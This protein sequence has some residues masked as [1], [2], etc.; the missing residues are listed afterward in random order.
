MKYGNI[1]K[2]IEK[3]NK[4]SFRFFFISGTLFTIALFI[5]YVSIFQRETSKDARII[6]DLVNR[7]M[8]YSSHENFE[9]LML[10]YFLTEVIA[11]IEYPIII[12]D[13]NHIPEFWKNID[14]PEGARWES[15]PEPTKRAMYARLSK[16]RKN[17]N[18][19]IP[20]I[21][22]EDSEQ[23]L[24]YVYYEDSKTI[25]LL[26]FLPYIEVL[27]IL[28]FLSLGTFALTSIHQNEKRMIWV[29]LA[30]ET[31]HQFG[32]PISSLICWLDFLKS[33]VEGLPAEEEYLAIINEMSTDISLLQ[34][35]TTRFGKFGTDIT[36]KTV[37][38]DIL[39]DKMLMYYKKRLPV[40]EQEI[41]ISYNPL[42]PH[43]VLN[44]DEDLMV[45]AF[46]NIINN[47][48]DAM[49]LKAG[50]I[51]IDSYLDNKKYVILFTDQGIG[52]QRSM[53]EPIFLPGVTTKKRGWGLGLSMSKR[54]ICEYHQGKI[55]VAQSEI[56]NGTTIEVVL[57]L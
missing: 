4:R 39:I 43:T 42:N 47:S 15:L 3:L 8:A 44:I 31:A 57:P 23:V 32:T 28:L 55:R 48:I 10:Q 45:W 37:D 14:A 9:S 21:S 24:A 27:M 38:I 11:N 12:T 52:L 22:P 36:L 46:E 29:G 34:K 56:D 35:A 26:K 54:I 25:K 51:T 40:M 20:L 6:P 33:K 50:N 2:R 30:K 13:S 5:V 41:T 17:K 1:L 19:I 53:F 16:I 49:W 7:F 18:Y